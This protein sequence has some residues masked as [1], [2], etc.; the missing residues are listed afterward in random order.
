MRTSEQRQERPL[1]QVFRPP[2]L[3]SLVVA[4]LLVSGI[5]VAGSALRDEKTTKRAQPTTTTARADDDHG[6]GADDH[7]PPA[8]DDHPAAVGD[9]APGAGRRGRARGRRAP[10]CRRTSSGWPTSA[11]IRVPST[12]STTRRPSTRRRRSRSTAAGTRAVASTDADVFALSFFQFK[13]PMA[14]PPEPNR[15]EVDITGADADPVRE[16]P[17]EAHHDHVVGL[18]RELLLRH[19]PGE[20]DQSRVRGRQHAVRRLHASTSSAPVGTS[21]RSASSTTR[22][23]STRASPCTA[24]SRCRPRLPPT[25][26]CASRCTSP[27]T[28]TI[29]CT[30]VTPCTCTAASPPTSPRR[31]RSRRAR[32]HRR[33]DPIPPPGQ[34][35]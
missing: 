35:A 30:A 12:A 4:A 34:P 6:P 33:P 20:P 21:R 26:A 8:H 23:T 3:V 5:A 29:S 31:R 10:R 16:L 15:T 2:V 7:D 28:S 27:S 22:T 9:A 32:S 1:R 18:G 14:A 13:D 11:S 25:A 19:A 24:T 17:A